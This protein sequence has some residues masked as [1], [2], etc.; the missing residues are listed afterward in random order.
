MRGGVKEASL[1]YQVLAERDGLSLVRVRLHTGRT[2]QIRVQFAS[3]GTPLVGDGRYG[4]GGGMMA[5]WSWSLSFPGPGGRT[6]AFSALPD[7]SAWEPFSEDLAA[8]R[9]ASG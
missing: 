4:G 1:A 9:P 8:L 6:L 3:R 7:G 2:H 5:L